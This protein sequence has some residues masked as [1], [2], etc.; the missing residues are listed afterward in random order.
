MGSLESAQSLKLSDFI[1]KK[2]LEDL[3]ADEE[4]KM[5]IQAEDKRSIDVLINKLSKENTEKNESESF[6]EPSFLKR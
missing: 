6:E 3:D 5:Q 2:F 1:D 4:Q